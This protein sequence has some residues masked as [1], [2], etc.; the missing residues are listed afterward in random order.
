MRWLD[1]IT[2]LVG[3]SLSMLWELVMDRAKKEPGLLAEK[4]L[5][6]KSKW[7]CSSVPQTGRMGLLQV[8]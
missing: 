4:G 6:Q 1:G 8:G 5:I 7:N 2:D 3:V